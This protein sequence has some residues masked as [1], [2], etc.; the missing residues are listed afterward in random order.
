MEIGGF[1]EKEDIIINKKNNN[2]D[3][4]K[5][6][7]DNIFVLSGRTAIDI[8]IQDI[9]NDKKV[10]TVYF[11]NYSCD[12]MRET[13]IR[14]GIKVEYYDVFFDGNSLRYNIDVQKKCDIFF[15]MNYFGYSVTNMD[16]YIKRFKERNVCVIEDITHSLLSKKNKSEYSDYYIASLRKWFPINSGGIAAKRMST[17]N[18]NKSILTYNDDVIKLKK[19]AMSLKKEYKELELRETNREYKDNLKVMFSNLYK[20]SNKY[21]ES[22]YINE[23]M[24]EESIDII[25]NIDINEIR[26]RI[27]L[28][29]NA[30]YNNLINRKYLI[31]EY[32]YGDCLLYVP[33]FVEKNKLKQIKDVIYKEGYYCPSHWPILPEINDLFENELSLICDYRY[34]SEEIKQKIL[35]INNI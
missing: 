21:L 6:G 11:P 27:Y 3:F 13:F 9:Q 19:Q 29:T 4:F 30:I 26:K 17:F 12:S 23:K 35:L 24:D 1:F 15:A 18:I 31:D 2:S 33:I 20:D 16:E 14:R 10:K 8:V 28:N 25:M 34:S 5:I 22:D 7:Y 32:K